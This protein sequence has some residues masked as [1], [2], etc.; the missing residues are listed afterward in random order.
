M[1]YVAGRAWIEALRIDTANHLFGLRLNDWTSL[2][3]FVA[4]G[5]FFV[6][7]GRTRQREPDPGRQ[8]GGAA[9]QGPAEAACGVGQSPDAPA[10]PTPRSQ[11]HPG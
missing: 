11:E 7:A 2:V 4:A 1:A 6:L 3:V 8:A 5:V 10:E 9:D